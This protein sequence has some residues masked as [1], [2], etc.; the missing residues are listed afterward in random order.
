MNENVQSLKLNP[1]INQVSVPESTRK[2]QKGSLYNFD[3][4]KQGP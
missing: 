3:T 4:S 1:K 2:Y